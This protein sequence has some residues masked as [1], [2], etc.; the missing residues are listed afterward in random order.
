MRIW[1]CIQVTIGTN[2]ENIRMRPSSWKW[3]LVATCAV[4]E[5]HGQR[6]SLCCSQPPVLDFLEWPPS[7]FFQSPPF[8]LFLISQI[9]L[10]PYLTHQQIWLLQLTNYRKK[11]VRDVPPPASDTTQASSACTDLI[12]N[13]MPFI[14]LAHRGRLAGLPL[15]EQGC[16]SFSI[17]WFFFFLSLCLPSTKKMNGTFYWVF[18]FFLLFA[19]FCLDYLPLLNI[20]HYCELHYLI[21][22]FLW[23]PFTIKNGCVE[24]NVLLMS[25]VRGQNGWRPWLHPNSLTNLCPYRR[26]DLADCITIR[27]VPDVTVS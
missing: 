8:V 17:L 23:S 1:N 19:L 22:H 10:T 26:F 13:T 6:E 15:Q 18:F 16:R 3:S 12:R 11:Y 21:K 2:G 25:G 20:M 4:A 14:I 5:P 9:K 24:E 7:L 27:D